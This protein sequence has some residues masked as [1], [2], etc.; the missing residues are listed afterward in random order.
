MAHQFHQGPVD[1]ALLTHWIHWPLSSSKRWCVQKDSQQEVG[2][3]S[4][5]DL[6]SWVNLRERAPSSPLQWVRAVLWHKAE[7]SWDDLFSRAPSRL[8]PLC[9][10]L[11]WHHLTS[12][13]EERPWSGIRACLPRM[14]HCRLFLVLSS[15][16]S[17]HR[18]HLPSKPVYNPMDYSLPGS[19]SHRILQARI[20]DGQPSPGSLPNPGIEPRS[21]ALQADSL[22]PEPPGNLRLPLFILSVS[23]LPPP[24]ACPMQI[25]ASTYHQ[26]GRGH[27]CSPE[28]PT[29]VPGFF[30]CS[31]FAGLFPFF[32][33]LLAT[34]ILDSFFYSNYLL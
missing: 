6:N 14:L 21:S 12:V 22:R 18:Y 4:L 20:L 11:W 15:S 2:K 31:L 29:P 8:P 27:A 19:S 9:A 28:G 17:Q 13:L 25:R 1:Y 10:P 23:S 32:V 30:L 26:S 33:C 16:G 3:G 24:H 34:A 5:R 7:H